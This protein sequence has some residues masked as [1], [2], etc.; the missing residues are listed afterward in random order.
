MP[1]ERIINFIRD[2]KDFYHEYLFNNRL[3]KCY[4][5]YTC[6]IDQIY[7]YFNLVDIKKTI[8]YKFYNIVSKN[9][10]VN[11]LHLLEIACGYIPILSSIY[12]ERGIDIDA[13]NNKIL[14]NNYKGVNTIEYDLNND[15]DL[16]KYDL[17]VGIRPCYVTENIID[18]CYKNK[19]DF[20]LYLCPCIHNSK[21]KMKFDGYDDWINYLKLKTSHFKNY[22][23]D[24]I[25]LDDFPDKCPIIIG[26]YIK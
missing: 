6:D 2:N 15:F 20:I 12:K 13:V 25:I 17:I 9:F 4:F 8:Y 21:S 7:C 18:N 26:R 23:V 22:N 16:S 5:G 14:I 3:S 24:F 11:K 19:K 10:K 1:D